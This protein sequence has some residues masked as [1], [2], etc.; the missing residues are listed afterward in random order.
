[1]FCPSRNKKNNLDF[2]SMHYF[3]SVYDINLS[4][5][6]ICNSSSLL[7]IGYNCSFTD[8]YLDGGIK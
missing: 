2:D 6:S 1:M 8:H 3:T 5:I 4:R 7:N